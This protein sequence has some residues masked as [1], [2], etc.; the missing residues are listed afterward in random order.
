MTAA[1]SLRRAHAATDFDEY[2]RH[3]AEALRQTLAER[4]QVLTPPIEE[5]A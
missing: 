2:R 1:E 3:L 5:A 4:E